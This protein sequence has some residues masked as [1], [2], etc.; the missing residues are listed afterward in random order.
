MKLALFD[1]DHTLLDGDSEDQ[2]G[3]YLIERGILDPLAYH[4][5]K[6]VFHQS[7][8]EGALD[9]QAL[10]TFQLEVL[11]AYPKEM[12]YEWREEYIKTRI[13]PLVLKKGLQVIQEHQ[14]QYH[15]IILITATNEFFTEPIARLLGIDH[16]ISTRLEKHPDGTYTGKAL[17]TPSYREG[18]VIRLD[19]WLAEQGRV[20]DD[21]EEIWF[22]S[23]SHNDLPLLTMVDHPIAVNPDKQLLE[24]SL[25]H[26]WKIMDFR[27]D[28]YI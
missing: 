18:K 3:S 1:L 8:R 26:N 21:Y 16:L 22:Y 9:I 28:G 19:E 25:K 24:Y 23:D 17:G 4:P 6:E 13:R 11:M 20:L 27:K 12:L 15:D 14:S 10:I 2:W 5:R 7:Y